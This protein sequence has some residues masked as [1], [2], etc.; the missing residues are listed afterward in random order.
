MSLEDRYGANTSKVE[1]DPKGGYWLNTTKG[2]QHFPGTP[3]EPTQ[4]LP[5]P[6]PVSDFLTK[7]SNVLEAPL[8]GIGAAQMDLMR[9]PYLG[10]GMGP[11]G[12]HMVDELRHGQ[13]GS[14]AQHYSTTSLEA[15]RERAQLG[16]PGAQ[17]LD[18]HPGM[19]FAPLA[20][21]EEFFN[22]SNRAFTALGG[23]GRAVGLKP[24]SPLNRFADVR[25][26]AAEA[27]AQR[28]AA[29]EAQAA[30]ASRMGAARQGAKEANAQARA[31]A[32]FAE[33][34]RQ[35]VQAQRA[36]QF[37][38]AW[39]ARQKAAIPGTTRPALTEPGA[40]FSPVSPPRPGTGYVP[41]ALTP[42][43]YALPPPAVGEARL[44]LPPPPRGVAALPPGGATQ[45]PMQ[46]AM[47]ETIA[48]L[49]RSARAKPTPRSQRGR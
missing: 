44:A 20:F 29:A 25:A 34:Q 37:Y 5:I 16:D 27:P 12:Q 17:L 8:T 30:R 15:N 11:S 38:E 10:I 4:P 33:K 43:R 26:A 9:K 2:R 3:P 48:N 6:Q 31:A 22:P 39:R 18:K 23:V 36:R 35:S 40:Q 1:I 21:V 19:L 32:H 42:G 41:P 24:L 14:A 7:A 47:R 45:I 49:K 46:N 13:F 28:A